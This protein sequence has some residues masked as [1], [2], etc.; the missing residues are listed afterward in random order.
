MV[1]AAVAVAGLA[2]CKDEKKAAGPAPTAATA[3]SQ[4]ALDA[5]EQTIQSA[6]PAPAK[7]RFRGVQVYAQAAPMHYAVCGQVS[8]FADDGNIFVPFVS[9]VTAQ[10]NGQVMQYQF[11]QRIGTTTSEASRVYAALVTY[12]YENGGP[13]QTGF[14]T[15]TPTPPL[16]D[17]VPD[18]AASAAAARVTPVAAA[19]AKTPGTVVPTEASGTATVRQSANVHSDPKGPTTRTV[20]QGTSLKIFGQAPGGWY[21]V[22]DT[23]PFGWVHESMLER[24]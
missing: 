24:R 23:A 19:G 12:C 9:V 10:Q 17:A 15:A 20:T 11:E 6:A 5:A 18:P 2:G 13:A 16:P 22:G 1:V 8:P 7:V 3:L 21:Q 14:R 4:R